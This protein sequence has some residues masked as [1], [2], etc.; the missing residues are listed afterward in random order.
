MEGDGNEYCSM[1]EFRS[2]LVHSLVT[3]LNRDDASSDVFL[4]AC[5]KAALAAKTSDDDAFA[6]IQSMMRH[7][8]VNDDAEIA[9]DSVSLLAYISSKQLS[10]IADKFSAPSSGY[11]HKD[12]LRSLRHCAANQTPDQHAVDCIVVTISFGSKT[13][14]V[15][16]VLG[17]HNP[18]VLGQIIRKLSDRT[19][20]TGGSYA[21][22]VLLANIPNNVARKQKEI[23]SK[24]LQSRNVWV[25]TGAAI[26][27]ISAEIDVARAEKVLHDVVNNAQE[28]EEIRLMALRA[29]VSKKRLR[30]V[31]GGTVKPLIFPTGGFIRLGY[32]GRTMLC[33]LMNAIASG[34]DVDDEAARAILSG[35]KRRDMS[36]CYRVLK[37]MLP[38]A[39][40]LVARLGHNEV[41]I[42]LKA[43]RD[44][45]ESEEVRKLT[46]DVEK[47]VK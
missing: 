14:A 8:L 4:A 22:G 42:A 18:E 32:C 30:I 46:I 40:K 43:I 39:P 5:G 33:E 3:V 20:D 35:L 24:S 2:D 44:T 21:F 19:M 37:T 6:I 29:L 47:A 36:T 17:R 10:K 13:D 25:R 7:E 31:S 28:K 1:L 11:R 15:G 26:A 41:K 27:I 38:V 34:V 9:N 12:Y 16:T 23:L 45:V